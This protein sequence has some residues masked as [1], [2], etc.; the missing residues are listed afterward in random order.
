M[1]MRKDDSA[2]TNH[3]IPT[4][5]IKAQSKIVLICMFLARLAFQSLAVRASAKGLK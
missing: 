1:S 4:V 2:E 3:S 5:N